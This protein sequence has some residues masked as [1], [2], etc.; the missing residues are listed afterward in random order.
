MMDAVEKRDEKRETPYRISHSQLWYRSLSST[1][2]F[3]DVDYSGAGFL[4]A[5]MVCDRIIAS[6]AIGR[7]IHWLMQSWYN[8]E[9]FYAW[10]PMKMVDRV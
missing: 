7:S 1:N 6:K 9:T 10:I 8:G 4:A 2:G 3:P 5:D